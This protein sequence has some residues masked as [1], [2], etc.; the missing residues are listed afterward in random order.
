MQGDH[1]CRLQEFVQAAFFH[2]VFAREAGG[3]FVV[4][5]HPA[6]ESPE[7]TGK[8]SPHVPEP[9]DT[10]GSGF[11]FQAAV[12]FAVPAAA[13]DVLVRPGEFVQQGEQLSHGV[14]PNG[15]GI[16]FGGGDDPHTPP[17]GFGHVNVIQTCPTARYPLQFRQ[18][19]EQR[20]IHGQ[21][22]TQHDAVA[23]GQRPGEHVVARR[24][25]SVQAVHARSRQ[26]LHE[27]FVDGIEE[28]D[29]CHQIK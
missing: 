20:C 6:P 25:F 5:Q 24:G 11:Q 4:R 19:V 2:T 28:C 23:G 1:I 22:R 7:A 14:F 29:V 8:R 3:V 13:A 9:D 15:R 10:H 16:A 26:A 12:A 21:P 18:R 27:H 17:F